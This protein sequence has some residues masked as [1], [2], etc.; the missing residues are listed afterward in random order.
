MRIYLIGAVLLL[1][2]ATAA[3]ALSLVSMSQATLSGPTASHGD[4]MLQR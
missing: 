4:A 3:S 1:I 2:A